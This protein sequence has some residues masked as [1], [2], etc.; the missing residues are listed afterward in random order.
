MSE[1]FQK[2][3]GFYDVALHGNPTSTEFF[4]ETIDAYML[5][6]IIRNRNDYIKGTKVRLLSCNTGNTESTGNCVAQIVAN[7]LGVQVEAPTD[8]IYV[9]PDGT[10]T[11]G[12]Y[13]DGFMKIF[14]PRK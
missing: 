2:K 7:E 14:Y 4:G 9:N 3:K 12:D 1:M 8:I 11:I 13:D 5:S 10:F 6:N